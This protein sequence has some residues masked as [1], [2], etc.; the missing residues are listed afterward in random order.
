VSISNYKSSSSKIYGRAAPTPKPC[1]HWYVCMCLGRAVLSELTVSLTAYAF[2]LCVT[3]S[4]SGLDSLLAGARPARDLRVEQALSERLKRVEKTTVKEGKEAKDTVQTPMTSQMLLV[5]PEDSP[6]LR[7]DSSASGAT[8]THSLTSYR[9]LSTTALSLSLSLSVCVCV[10][11]CVCVLLCCRLPTSSYQSRITRN[12]QHIARAQSLCGTERLCCLR[13]CLSRAGRS[14]R[15]SSFG[16]LPS[17]RSYGGISSGGSFGREGED[18]H[19]APCS[20]A[21]TAIGTE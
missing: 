6:L 4:L 1:R 11:V 21:T 19:G 15:G 5:T 13:S 2:T 17:F 7:P 16:S 9:D 10:C 18:R 14:A 20:P 8:I 3:V 12:A